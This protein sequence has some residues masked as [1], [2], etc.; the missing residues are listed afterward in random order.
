MTNEKRDAMM[1]KIRGLIAKADATDF[2]AEADTFR[3]AADALMLRYSISEFELKPEAEQRRS[4]TSRDVDMAWYL[5]NPWS[6]E[7]YTI[8]YY[9][10]KHCRC[11]IVTW[12]FVGVT[13]PVVGGENDLDF[14]DML[15]TN[16]MLEQSKGLEPKPHRDEPM[17]EYLVRAKEAGMKWERIA[18]IMLDYG[19]ADFEVYTRNVGVRFTKLYT[20]YCNEHNRPRLRTS[21]GVFQ[22]SFAMGFTAEIV[23]RLNRMRQENLAEYDAEHEAGGASLVLADISRT[24]EARAHEMFGHPPMVKSSGRARYRSMPERKID[25]S[26][27]DAGRQAARQVNLGAGQVNRPAPAQI[28]RG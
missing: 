16:I 1:A 15:F 20:D 18:E 26:A 24:V 22:R 2:P 7:L 21:P 10:A 9:V 5:A 12:K 17:I 14:M 8:F 6:A 3:K 28:E 13:I 11:K 4:I 19:I 23:G 27:L 25:H